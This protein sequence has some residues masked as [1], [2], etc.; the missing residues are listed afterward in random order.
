MVAL[1]K[2]CS[3]K[4]REKDKMINFKVPYIVI[5]NSEMDISE[6]IFNKLFLPQVQEESGSPK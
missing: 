5:N 2:G 3:I 1:K 6:L 4:Q